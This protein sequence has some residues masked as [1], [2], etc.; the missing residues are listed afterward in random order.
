MLL[1]DKPIG[2]S[3]NDALQKARRLFQAARA[4]HTGTLDPLA[5]GLLPVC[6]GDATRFAG[7]MLD[8]D[9]E[10]LAQVRLGVRTSTGDAEGEILD[11]RPVDVSLE[12][13]LSALAAHRGDIDQIPPMHSALKHQGKA[14][15]E[16]ARAGET[17][18][19]A[20]RHVRIH[21]I[22][23]LDCAMPAFSMRVRCSKGTYIRTLAEDIGEM[24][25]CGAHLSGLRRT[26]TGPLSLDTAHTLE[27]LA[28]LDE[29]QRMDRLL[30]PDCLLQDLPACQLDGESA[31]R[32][33]QGQIV[34]L[35][36]FAD[37]GSMAEGQVTRAY[38]GKVFL[39]LVSACSGRLQVKRLL[40]QESG[41][42]A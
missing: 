22:E 19:R 29:A 15:Y 11:T 26:L 34:P 8:A 40:P 3:S 36:A 27:T 31:R 42:K 32:L 16:Y 6:F 39:G 23:L 5:S 18:E 24:L 12:R 20:V 2:L 38:D 30:P 10:Y 21:D 25:D 9:K 41:Q 35:E 17:I 33:I 14:L 28:A 1:L 37:G 7:L 13:L 4:G